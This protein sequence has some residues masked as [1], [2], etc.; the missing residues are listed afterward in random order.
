M[1]KFEKYLINEDDT[2]KIR[3]EIKKRL[4]QAQSLV[5]Q[6]SGIAKK[7]ENYEK[8]KDEIS[9]TAEQLNQLKARF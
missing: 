4:S 7:L 3:A 6:A 8:Y 2:S 5:S 9:D 1:K